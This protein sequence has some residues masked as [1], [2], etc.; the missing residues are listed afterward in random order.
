MQDFRK[1]LNDRI[2]IRQKDN[3]TQI[4]HATRDQF[5][6][7][8]NQ[9]GE[10]D[11]QVNQSNGRTTQTSAGEP[12]FNYLGQSYKISELLSKK[13]DNKIFPS[14]FEIQINNLLHDSFNLFK[15]GCA[16]FSI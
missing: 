16:N 10:F 8:L 4:L 11:S 13:Y 6:R 1:N 7:Y 2:Q 14:A 3:Y 5:I 15:H 9:Q 12:A